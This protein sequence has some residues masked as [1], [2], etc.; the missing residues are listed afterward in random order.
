MWMVSFLS[1][2]N[3]IVMKL[4]DLVCFLFY[5]DLIGF[6]NINQVGVFISR[7]VQ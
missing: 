1:S 3:G 6:L 4:A 7:G 2:L 5:H